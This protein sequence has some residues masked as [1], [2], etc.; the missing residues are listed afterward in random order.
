MKKKNYSLK[1]FY[2]HIMKM[3]QKL[4]ILHLITVQKINLVKVKIH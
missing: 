1:I 3:I 2:K 4:Y